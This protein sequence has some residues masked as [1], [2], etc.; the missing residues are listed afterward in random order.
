M[1]CFDDLISLEDL[2]RSGTV[3]AKKKRLHNRFMRDI[4]QLASKYEYMYH[5][6]I[7]RNKKL[8][9]IVSERERD[10]AIVQRCMSAFMPYILAYNVAQMSDPAPHEEG[11]GLGD[12]YGVSGL[13]FIRSV[14]RAQT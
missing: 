6:Y 10:I 3:N 12:G 7:L 14:T 8:K 5:K 13:D 2:L 1:Q 9:T 11:G 4:G